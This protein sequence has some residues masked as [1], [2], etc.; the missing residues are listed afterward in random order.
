MTARLFAL[1]LGALALAGS[2]ARAQPATTYT[3]KDGTIPNLVPVPAPEARCGALSEA[4]GLLAFG[5]DVSHPSAHVSLVRLDAKG[6]PAP[7][8][9]SWKLPRPEALI[10]AKLDHFPTGLAFHPKL[11]LL[12]VWQ[13]ITLPYAGPPANLSP[14][15]RQFDHLVIY[16]VAKDPP[17]LVAALCRGFDYY[18]HGQQGGA[19]AVGPD[20]GHLYVPSLRAPKNPGIQHFARFALDADGLPDLGEKDGKLPLPQRLKRLAELNAAPVPFQPAE[21]TPTEYVYIF[22]GHG[23]G[24]GHSFLPVGRDV[25]LAGSTHGVVVWRPGDKVVTLSAVPLRKAD[26]VL[27]AGHP[28]LPL[29]YATAALPTDSLF[30]VAHADGYPTLLP[31]QWVL[32]EAKLSSP[33]AVF[34]KGRAV[35]VGGQYHVYRFRLDGE[36]RPTGDVVRARVLS[37]QV[38][39]LTY[40]PRF[41]RLYCGVE[42]S[43]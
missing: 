16:N 35:A 8:A 37:P 3:P 19:V 7:Y 26:H 11:P 28:E 42:L 9:V 31:E 41:D 25:I 17:E 14:E 33:P 10:K 32:P 21:K 6:N 36:G 20:G 29:V 1:A 40:S 18:L 12:Y 43:K 22:P 27:L 34:E 24:C 39:A 15:A 5:H 2:P 13:D 23:Y 38:R 30:R 4:H